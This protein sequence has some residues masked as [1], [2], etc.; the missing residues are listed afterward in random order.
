MLLTAAD[1]RALPEVGEGLEN[2]LAAAVA[3]ETSLEGILRAVKTK[4]YTHARLRRILCCAALGITEELQA[5]RAD[6][7]RVLGFTDEGARL[8]KNCRAEVVTSVARALRSG[9]NVDFLRA[10]IRATD[11]AALAYERVKPCGADYHTKIIR[12]KCAK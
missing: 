4:R 2:R 7:V 9:R 3:A 10:D 12:E 11:L 8:L 6:Y 1:F 5:R